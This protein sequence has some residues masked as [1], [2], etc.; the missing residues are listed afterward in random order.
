MISNSKSPVGKLAPIRVAAK[1]ARRL[2]ISKAPFLPTE[3][4]VRRATEEGNGGDP[5]TGLDGC[6]K[7]G[8]QKRRVAILG[9]QRVKVSSLQ[10]LVHG[11]HLLGLPSPPATAQN[12]SL[13]CLFPAR[14]G[15]FPGNVNSSQVI[16]LWQRQRTDRPVP[17]TLWRRRNCQ[18]VKEACL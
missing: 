18:R 11:C 5:G 1:R 10:G 7:V 2:L 14:T 9:F 6:E 8:Q 3:K 15:Q 13:Q 16:A 17:S 12:P 4:G